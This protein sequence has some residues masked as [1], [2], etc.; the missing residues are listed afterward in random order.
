LSTTLFRAIPGDREVHLPLVEG[1]IRFIGPDVESIQIEELDYGS[2]LTLEESDSLNE[3]TIKSPGAILSF[4]TFPKQTV[5][6]LGPIEEIRVFEKNIGY[7]LHR[8]TSHPTLPLEQLWGAVITRE[9]QVDCEEYDA[10]MI[11]PDQVEDLKI[12]G[13]WSQIAI[14][15]DK[16]LTSVE[17]EGSRVIRDFVIHKGPA[18]SKLNIKR[19]VLNCSILKCP[20]VQTIIGFGDRLHIQP[21]PR[22]NSLSVGGFWH[23]VPLWY[24]EQIAMLRVPHFGAHLSA[25]DIRKC[26]DIGGVTVIPH[27]YE[28]P[29]GLCQFSDAFNIPIDELSLGI[30]IPNMIQMIEG[31]PKVGIDVLAKWCTNNL[32]RFDQYKAMRIIASLISRGF[33]QSSILQI[34]NTLS[35]MNKAMPMLTTETV[36]DVSFGIQGGRWKLLYFDDDNSGNDLFDEWHSPLNSVMPFGRIDLE[37]WLN[38]DLEWEYLGIDSDTM[39]LQNHMM[40]RRQLGK[41]PVIRNLLISSLSAANT[42]G[43]HDGAE[44]KLTALAQSLY[45]NPRITTDPFCCEFTIY[46]IG[47]SRIVEAGPEVVGQLINGII[48]MRAKA[49]IRATLLIGIVDQINS[50]RARMALQRLASDPEFSISE[51]SAINAVAIAGRRAFESGKVPKPTWPYLKNWKNIQ[52]Y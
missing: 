3:I 17:V 37:I 11:Y 22:N 25:D 20:N 48:E 36:N 27:T 23:S 40:G 14:I 41:N 5:R 34:R 47:V 7:M 9:P 12:E 4:P 29:G 19:R 51:S 43:R 18:L 33:D 35:K 45:T 26:D 15:G 52:N 44:D 6:I 28:G 39:Q 50:P 32:S 8:V 10:L 38:T 30:M 16:H 46:H 2:V 49:W 1:G 21:K 13:N 31:N 42:V 24:D